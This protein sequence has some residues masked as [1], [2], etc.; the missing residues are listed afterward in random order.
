MKFLIL[1]GTRSSGKGNWFPWLKA[2]LEALGHEV[3]APDLPGADRPNPARYNEFL[4]G[5]KWDFNDCVIIG[6]SSGSVAILS[7]LE[8]LPEDVK[9][10]TAVLVGAFNEGMLK[11]HR[12]EALKDLF[13]KTF[14][15]EL[16]KQKSGK[17]VFVHS[18]DDP[19]CPIEQAEELCQKLEG[20]MIRFDGMGHFIIKHD[21]RF[22]KFP[23][24]LEIIKTKII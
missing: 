21:P 6:H 17:F 23:E 1:H 10:N 8:A 18:K 11:S 15:Y 20:E 2:E 5:Q 19:N 14:D 3:W 13:E 12:W 7:L 24:L 4:L 9:I 22:D 16:I